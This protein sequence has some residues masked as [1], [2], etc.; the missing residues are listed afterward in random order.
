MEKEKKQVVY[1]E[2]EL[3]FRYNKIRELCYMR[4]DRDQIHPELDNMTYLE[5][6][7]NNR[8][9]DLS[10]IPPKKNRA[11]VRVVTGTTREKDTTLLSTLLNLNLEPNI[12]AFD[13]DDMVVAE[14]GDNMSDSVKKSRE[15][16]NYDKKRPIIYR[17]MISQGDVFVQEIHVD[18]FRKVPIGS[19]D[20]DPSTGEAPVTLGRH[21]FGKEK[22]EARRRPAAPAGGAGVKVASNVKTRKP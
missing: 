10:F 9:K 12:T 17:E 13:T 21:S 19:V 4:D 8:K 20:W 16:E 5:Y 2:E 15:I 3:K 6:Y 14:L 18:D 1:A 7:D 11:D 22:R